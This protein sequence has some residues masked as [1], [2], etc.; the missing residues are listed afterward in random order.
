MRLPVFFMP[1]VR[2]RAPGDLMHYVTILG[3]NEHK[4]MHEGHEV[5]CTIDR[6]N[7]KNPP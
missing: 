5:L 4:G 7:S 2:L 6:F 1:F 3:H